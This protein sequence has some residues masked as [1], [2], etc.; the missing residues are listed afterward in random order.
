ML[1]SWIL[2]TTDFLAGPLVCSILARCLILR[3]RSKAPSNWTP[4][5]SSRILVIRPGGI[6]DMILLLPAISALTKH[7]PSAQI[8]I[9]CERRNMAVIEL[10]DIKAR[11]IAYDSH[12][13][14][15]V[16]ILCKTKY[17][18]A[19]D[20][21]QFHH[22]SAV[23]A[24]LSGADVRIGFNINPRR[25]GLYTHLIPYS[26]DGYE[27]REFFRMLKPLGITSE[28]SSPGSTSCKAP[29]SS[30]LDKALL[31][32]LSNMKTQSKLIVLHAGGSIKR[33]LWP[34]S[35]ATDLISRLINSYKASIIIL[36]G[37]KDR[38]RCSSIYSS[39]ADSPNVVNIMGELN[40]AQ[41]AELIAMS[42]MFIGPD[43]GLLHLAISLNRP[44]IAIFGPSD[45]RKWGIED[46]AHKIV[47]K[48][49]PC[50]PCC[51]FG[52]SKPCTHYQCIE[53]ISV[54]EVAQ[55]AEE[56]MSSS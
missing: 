46:K 18:I 5:R 34:E 25:N 31:D 36:G 26:P 52:Y 56:L 43:S 11:C 6:G 45:H 14:K 13:L 32:R 23:F 19:V 33:K 4:E 44:T 22:F 39:F 50:A 2:K 37:N 29:S 42:G 55:A 48:H 3:G 12:P 1:R 8:D 38:E 41:C 17:D 30:T 16:N 54:E 21:E 15:L 47:R 53:D 7:F 10:T 49:L 51:I 20:S 40:L 9:V 24:A 27:G 35:K 28:T